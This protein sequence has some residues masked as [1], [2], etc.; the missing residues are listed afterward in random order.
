MLKH[1]HGERTS[2]SST[3]WMS[4]SASPVLSAV[5]ASA[6]SPEG[7]AERRATRCIMVVSMAR[8]PRS[9]NVRTSGSE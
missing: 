8:Y 2:S 5:V 1:G 4:R 7:R 9:S 3:K 6:R